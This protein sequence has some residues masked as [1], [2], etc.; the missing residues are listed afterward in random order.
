MDFDMSGCGKCG[1]WKWEILA[2]CNTSQL[3]RV[4]IPLST[5]DQWS[6][7]QQAIWFLCLCVCWCGYGGAGSCHW[8]NHEVEMT[9]IPRKS[10]FWV[11]LSKIKMNGSQSCLCVLTLCISFLSCDISTEISSFDDELEKTQ[12]NSSIS[13]DIW[14]KEVDWKSDKVWQ[15]MLAVAVQV[16]CVPCS[17]V[18][19]EIPT[20]T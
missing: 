8:I 10:Y 14:T 11:Y 9:I 16:L 13:S 6:L 1:S 20:T 19:N 15:N 7:K 12:S 2:K 5:T 3:S 17:L 18:P 4:M